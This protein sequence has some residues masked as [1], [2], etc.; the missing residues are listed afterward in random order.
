MMSL[1]K[2]EKKEEMRRM[3]KDI[4]NKVDEAVKSQE[5]TDKAAQDLKELKELVSKT[6]AEDPMKADPKAV[7]PKP[8]TNTLRSAR[9]EPSF[10]ANFFVLLLYQ[11]CPRTTPPGREKEN[12]KKTEGVR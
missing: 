12:T 1:L 9:K 11:T 6:E 8:V 7:D 10:L 4:T 5:R 2:D 3:A